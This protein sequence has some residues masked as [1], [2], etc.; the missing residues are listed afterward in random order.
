[1]ADVLVALSLTRIKYG[2]KSALCKQLRVIFSTSVE[3]ARNLLQWK[4]ES[5]EKLLRHGGANF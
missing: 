4:F 2:F 3:I 1:M 5:V